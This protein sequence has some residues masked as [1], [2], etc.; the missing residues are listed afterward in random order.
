MNCTVSFEFGVVDAGD[1]DDAWL[2]PLVHFALALALAGSCFGLCCTAP[3][4]MEWFV[5][6]SLTSME[7]YRGARGLSDLA[8]ALML[9]GG[10]LALLAVCAGVF[11]VVGVMSLLWAVSILHSGGATTSP[12]VD[13]QTG[14]AP[15][16][17][18]GD[19]CVRGSPACVCPGDALEL[20]LEE[21]AFGAV[22]WLLLCVVILSCLQRRHSDDGHTSREE[23]TADIGR[24]STAETAT[25]AGSSMKQTSDSSYP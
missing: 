18:D 1:A 22:G 24:D 6:S 16:A 19:P 5:T 3:T 23:A 25:L 20:G 10:V 8:G 7:P 12:G 4:W 9:V 15:E 17:V 21:A 14:A 13:G 11:F 2:A